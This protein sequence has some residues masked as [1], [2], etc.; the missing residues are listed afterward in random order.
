MW[1]ALQAR[2][3]GHRAELMADAHEA[4]MARL[5]RLARRSAR[6]RGRTQRCGEPAAAVATGATQQVAAATLMPSG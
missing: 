5:A 4:G 6:G 1:F 3:D 2:V